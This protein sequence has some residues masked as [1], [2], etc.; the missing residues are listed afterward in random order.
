MS[1][2]HFAVDLDDLDR[3]VAMLARA[4]DRIEAAVTELESRL[5]RLRGAWQ[6]PA[7]EAQRAAHEEWSRGL[8]QMRAA[9]ADFRS[10][11][12]TAHSNYAEAAEVN[13]RMWAATR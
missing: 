8:A 13:L 7:A 9:L 3:T 2:T 10:R 5:T 4:G 11:S 1:G 12:R 6:G